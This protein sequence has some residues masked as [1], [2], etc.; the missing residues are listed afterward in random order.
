MLSW[1]NLEIE[2][3]GADVIRPRE[4]ISQ[5]VISEDGLTISVEKS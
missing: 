3:R 1:S 2:L 5:V 4:V